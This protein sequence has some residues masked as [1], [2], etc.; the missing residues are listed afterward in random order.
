MTELYKAAYI[1]REGNNHDAADKVYK[2]FIDTVKNDL[3]RG[4]PVSSFETTLTA[5]LDMV[6]CDVATIDRIAVLN[7]LRELCNIEGYRFVVYSDNNYFEI[8]GWVKDQEEE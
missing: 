4:T 7:Y 3:K 8:D 1:V 5:A 2:L 6:G